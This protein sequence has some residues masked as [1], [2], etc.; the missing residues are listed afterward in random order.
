MQFSFHV[1][2]VS[3][4]TH[5][6]KIWWSERDQNQNVPSAG[7]SL[8]N[9]IKFFRLELIDTDNKELTILENWSVLRQTLFK[10]SSLLQISICDVQ[11]FLDISQTH[12]RYIQ[13]HQTDL[14][15]P[16]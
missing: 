8:L 4:V 5:A 14:E 7:Q 16:E 11:N 15:V 13:T 12:L 10:H 1:D 2:M 9:A 6:D 3:F